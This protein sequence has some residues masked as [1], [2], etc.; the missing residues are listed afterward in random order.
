MSFFHEMLTFLQKKDIILAVNSELAL[1]IL[2]IV[3]KS[4]ILLI[5]SLTANFF[6]IVIVFLIC[7]FYNKILKEMRRGG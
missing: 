4:G 7:W 2:R 3:Q 5:V 6:L 1:E